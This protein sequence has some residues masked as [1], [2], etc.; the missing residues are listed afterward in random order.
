MLLTIELTPD[1]HDRVCDY[2]QL[3]ALPARLYRTGPNSSVY[4][5][6]C[7]SAQGV[8]LSLLS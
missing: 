3:W 6:Q 7:D 1:N 4:L 5:V 2:I 8:W